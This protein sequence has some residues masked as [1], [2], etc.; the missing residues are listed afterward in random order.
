MFTQWSLN[1]T[2]NH[3]LYSHNNKFL[4]TIMQYC[5]GVDVLH[6]CY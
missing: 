2:L 4:M 1:F 5:S 6:N 3:G